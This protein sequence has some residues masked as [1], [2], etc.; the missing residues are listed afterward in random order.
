M[1][2]FILKII[3]SIS[4]FIVAGVF[5]IIL[6]YYGL[7]EIKPIEPF[8][9]RTILPQVIT[10]ACLVG[11]LY[12][13][14]DMFFPRQALRK[15]SFGFTVLIKSAVLIFIFIIGALT[16]NIHSNIV[17]GH[18]D[19]SISY[20]LSELIF[21]QTKNTAVTFLYI[22]TVV[23]LMNFFQEINKKFGPGVLFKI[24]V[25]KYH[26]PREEQRI[27]MFVDLKSSTMYAEQLGH[28]K[29]SE[30]IQDCF[31]DLSDAVL[32]HKA[33]I[34]QYVGDEV[35]LTWNNKNGLENG[36]CLL[37]YYSFISLINQ[38]KDYYQGKYKIIPEFK[39]GA[40]LGMVTIAEVGR[41]KREIAYHG[42]AINTAA[43]IQQKCGE[44]NKKILISEL[45]KN[46]LGELSNL[47]TELEGNF[48]LKGK[49]S[50]LNIYSIKE[51]D[52]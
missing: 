16:V 34:Y 4:F 37:A 25:G 28:I 52:K 45:L 42:D 17:E 3:S 24:F 51:N 2:N 13:L 27:F 1:K 43:R 12:A 30:L 23:I 38:R 49:K 10:S 5:L 31:Y 40:S 14:I 41:I 48:N 18:Y 11:L 50:P 9:L 35:V 7:E 26:K 47:N 22:S 46:E 6:R 39:A 8:N 15:R 32:R 36:N 29:Y 44:L 19:R 20:I 21:L 33:E